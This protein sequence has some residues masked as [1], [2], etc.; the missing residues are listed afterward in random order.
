[1]TPV[2]DAILLYAVPGFV[3]FLVL[4]ILWDL[5]R[6]TAHYEWKDAATSIA[7]GLGSLVTKSMSKVMTLGLFFLAWHNRLFEIPLAWWSLLLLFF[8]ED[9][10]YYWY[11]RA[12][13]EIPAFWAAHVAHHSSE[14]YHLAT[15]L[16]QP[17]TTFWHHWIF[18]L[19]L[20][21]LG[22][23]PVWIFTAQA[24]NLIYQ[25]WIHTPFIDRLGPLEW[26]LNTPSH[27]RVHHGSN[28]R[29]I[30][31]NHGG[32]FILWDRL[33]GTFELE[34]EKVRYG[35]TKPVH[36]YNPLWLNLHVYADLWHQAKQSGSVW[37]GL[38]VFFARR[39][40]VQAVPESALAEPSRTA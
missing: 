24:I 19:P 26:I 4:E 18:W 32:I 17:W 2:Y 34:T 20:A 40:R 1:M 27:H 23:H 21:W 36:S 14:R 33:Y 25:F 7:L 9:H 11:H 6:G 15:A 22:F 39:P 13:H 3:L 37:Q 29:Y 35:I 16:R 38:K 5:R 12:S 10:S 30:D 31:R 8:L 28:P